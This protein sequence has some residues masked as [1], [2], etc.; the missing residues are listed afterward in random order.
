MVLV[1]GFEV[2]EEAVGFVLE[3][4][5]LDSDCPPLDSVL[6][7]A[8]CSEDVAVFSEVI[9]DELETLDDSAADSLGTVADS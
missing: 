8:G 5:V 2:V 3:G 7:L 9:D 6:E 4:T 1:D